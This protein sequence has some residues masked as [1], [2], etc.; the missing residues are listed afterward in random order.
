MPT[1]EST[2]GKVT[3]VFT[4][5]K[6]TP[7]AIAYLKEATEAG[8]IAHAIVAEASSEPVNSIAI[9]V[10]DTDPKQLLPNATPITWFAGE[11]NQVVAFLRP[12]SG[13]G[14]ARAI[15]H[16]LKARAN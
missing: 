7:D 11:D 14:Y 12:F 15:V 8:A 13:D 2:K 16:G 1:A 3:V 5:P 9:H 10:I 6:L 4:G